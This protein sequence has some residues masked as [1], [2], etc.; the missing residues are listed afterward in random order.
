M[1]QRQKDMGRGQEQGL[2]QGRGQG[3]GGAGTPRR[4]EPLLPLS[5]FNME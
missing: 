5:M 1:G 4:S 3:Q 2:E